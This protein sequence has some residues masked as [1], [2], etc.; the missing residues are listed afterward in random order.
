MAA[1]WNAPILIHKRIESTHVLHSETQLL[2]AP[3]SPDVGYPLHYGK[4]GRHT[5]EYRFSKNYS[6]RINVHDSSE[7]LELSDQWYER[8]TPLVA[9]LRIHTRGRRKII[10]FAIG[11][12]S[13]APII[14]VHPVSCLISEL[15]SE[16][17]MYNLR[18]A[19]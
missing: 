9:N 12:G 6:Q 5:T 8:C 7:R 10:L 1:G 13:D 4:G 19:Q 17:E 16:D 2:T 3:Q 14:N 18:H 11:R 15:Y